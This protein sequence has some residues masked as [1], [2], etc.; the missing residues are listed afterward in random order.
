METQTIRR[1]YHFCRVFNDLGFSGVGGR[2]TG[3]TTD[4]QRH[5]DNQLLGIAED[6]G[7]GRR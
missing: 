4:E 6:D 3:C 1:R 5:A 2:Q 7:R